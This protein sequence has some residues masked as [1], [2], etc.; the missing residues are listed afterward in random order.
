MYVFDSLIYNEGRTP[1]RIRYSVDNFQLI[2]V[3]HDDALSTGRGRPPVLR[4]VQLDINASWKE[5]LASL[6]EGRLTDAL[7]DVMDE[8]RIRA[9]LRRGDELLEQN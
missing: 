9:L 6:D 4:D 2:L 8:R 5:A 7:G 1:E 3:G